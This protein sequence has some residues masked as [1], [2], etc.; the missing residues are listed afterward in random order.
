MNNLER[1]RAD[2]HV[3]TTASDGLRSPEECVH[4]ANELGLDIIGITDH[5]RTWGALLALE[6]AR[7]LGGSV[8]VV[9]GT[10]ITTA[11]GHLL[12][13]YVKEEI[14]S[15]GSLFETVREIHYRGGLAIAPHVGLG[16]SPISI[17]PKTIANLYLKGE[18]LDGIEVLNPHYRRRHLEQARLLSLKYDISPVAGSDDHLGNFGR[19]VQTLFL[20]KT[21]V[22][23]RVSIEEGKTIA[24]RSE[25]PLKKIPVS[26][27]ILQISQGLTDD[28][29]RKTRRARIFV[30]TLI[31]LRLEEL[32]DKI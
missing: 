16:P 2:L 23:L 29:S 3:H 14:P 10:E 21:A 12:A 8:S 27:R 5:D 24:V 26:D 18:R 13:L 28:L 32:R 20:G 22:D 9:P 7:K 25:F 30:S 4:L 31:S 1:G 6:E 11:Q 19:E 17:S 15:M